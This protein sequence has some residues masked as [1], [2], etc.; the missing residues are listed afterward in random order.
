MWAVIDIGSNTIRLVIYTIDNG[1]PRPMLNKKYAVGLA[2]YIDKA[3]CIKQ[4]GI[5]ILLT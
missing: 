3:N 1:H 2:A 4:E 5:N